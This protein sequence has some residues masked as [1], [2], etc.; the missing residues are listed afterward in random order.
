M[1]F[2]NFKPGEE[3]IRK[4]QVDVSKYLP[5]FLKNDG[6]FKAV[7]DVHSMEHERIRKLLP[8]VFA[9]FSPYTATWGLSLWE[10]VL[11]L[12][13]DPGSTDNYRRAQILARLKGLNTSTIDFMNTVINTYGRGY[14]EEHNDRYYF[15]V[16]VA[17]N[18]N[19]A[20]TMLKH[21]LVIY[22]PAHLGINIYL[23][24]AWN[25][26]INFDGK[27]NFNA[28]ELDWSDTQA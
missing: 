19:A 10:K 16:Y 15:N 3:F 14:I 26:G 9:Q 22:R 12:Y 17:C 5:E 18:D 24:F 6:E 23:G 1:D 7:C 25:G 4:N 27:N 11:E 21:D 2:D 28:T 13:P 20:L 8:E